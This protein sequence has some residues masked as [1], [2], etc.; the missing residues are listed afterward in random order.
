[1]EKLIALGTG[2]ALPIKNRGAS[3][4]VIQSGNSYY[5]IDC[6][7]GTQ[8][9]L[10][11]LKIPFL[12]I[13]HIFISHLHGDHFLGLPGLISSFNLLNRQQKLCVYGPKG[14]KEIIHII[15]KFS[16]TQTCFELEF[17]EWDVK[18][19]EPILIE[20]NKQLQISTFSL[21]HRIPCFGYLFQEK[22]KER[23]LL[24]SAIQ[25]YNIPIQF[26]GRIKQGMDYLQEDGHVIPNSLLTED[27]E[28][29]ISYAYCSDNRV[30]ENQL[31]FLQNTN[32]LYHEAT[33]TQELLD[34]AKTTMH[35]TAYEAASLAKKLNVDKLL[36]GHF[37]ARYTDVSPIEKEA[38]SIF[39]NSIAL[40]DG[41]EIIF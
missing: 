5:L 31:E 41:M 21:N 11:D 28:V 22:A 14:L 1:M 13:N 17:I 26:R 4:Q 37:S 25:K 24:S 20:E 12:R 10:R 34:R 36:L 40:K 9:K 15:F 3:S 39:P 7:E 29:P 6:G 27:A 35:S 33:F 38:K 32:Y 19:T 8:L 23:K 16:Y 30:K 2:S 18:I